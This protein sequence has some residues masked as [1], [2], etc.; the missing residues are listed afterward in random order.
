[1]YQ[2]E[3]PEHSAICQRKTCKTSYMSQGY[4]ICSSEIELEKVGAISLERGLSLL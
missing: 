1:M 3:L 4:K 2:S